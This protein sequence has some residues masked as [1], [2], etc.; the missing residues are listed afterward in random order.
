MNTD[1]NS[2]TLCP[3]CS[4]H[5]VLLDDVRLDGHGL[6]LV[7]LLVL[8]HVVEA[9]S[10]DFA[11]GL[12]LGVHVVVHRVGGGLTFPKL[13]VHLFA[14]LQVLLLYHPPFVLV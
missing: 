11:E 13:C 12:H 3:S 5:Q 1:A 4:L 6:V 2:C 10:V 7:D 14:L 9:Q 8:H